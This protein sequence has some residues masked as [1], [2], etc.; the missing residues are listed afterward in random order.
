[1]K[2]FLSAL[3]PYYPTQNLTHAPIAWHVR[4]LQAGIREG[5]KLGHR[6]RRVDHAAPGHA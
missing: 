6:H 2:S 4:P 5:K 1:M 3:L